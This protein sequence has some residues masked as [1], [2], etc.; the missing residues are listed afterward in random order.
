VRDAGVERGDLAA[1]RTV[2]HHPYPRAE[3]R[4]DRGRP[5]LG[6]VV[7]DDDLEAIGRV[8]LGEGVRELAREEL[9]LV[10]RRDDD[11]QEG[12]VVLGEALRR[13][14]ALAAGCGDAHGDRVAD[15]REGRDRQSSGEQPGRRLHR[16]S[17]VPRAAAG[18]GHAERRSA[19]CVRVTGG[20]PVL[21]ACRPRSRSVP[22]LS[23]GDELVP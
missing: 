6:A 16:R 5:V 12:Q 7:D 23:S 22:P 20:A 1:T 21:A 13:E 15:V 19:R 9:L 4:G 11:G 3:R 8:V 10:V 18:R 17:P 14:A 2:L